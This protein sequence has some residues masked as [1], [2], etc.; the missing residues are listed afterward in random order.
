MMVP[1]SRRGVVKVYT[2]CSK[3]VRDYFDHLPRLAEDYPWD[4][5]ISYMFG[6]VELAQNNTLYCGMVKLHKVDSELAKKAIDGHP[7]HRDDFKNFYK[8]IF[9]R[10]AKQATFCKLKEAATIRDRILHGKQVSEKDKRKAI[11][12]I[13]DFAVR[14]NHD[15]FEIAG[16]KPFGVLRGFKGAG[17]PLG[18]STSRWV[19]KGIGFNNM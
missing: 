7:M 8:A 6:L 18:K 14:F 1:G 17:K 4:V 15:L 9:A 12:N 11:V 5:C 3:E 13:L 2:G 19:L 10:N 16:F